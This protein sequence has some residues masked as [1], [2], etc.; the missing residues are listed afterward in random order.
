M[1]K[2]RE[3]AGMA[4]GGSTQTKPKNGDRM[5]K[6]NQSLVMA[7]IVTLCS[8]SCLLAQDNPPPQGR[9]GRRG[10]PDAAQ[11]QQFQQQ[12]MDRLKEQLEVTDETEW[13]A[14]QPLIQKVTDSQRAAFSDMARGRFGGGRTRGGDNP[15]GDQGG[16]GGGF[17]GAPSPE[18]EALQKAI[19]GK[20]SKS[21]LKTALENYQASRKAK[22]AELEKAQADLR[23]VLSMRQEAIATANGLL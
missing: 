18:A 10:P 22:Q 12:R 7:G 21:E 2:A 16:R 6:M 5:M 9:Q 15:P 20:A 11:I 1:F 19:D 17:F 3:A 23:K 4:L 13:K 8:T 14:I